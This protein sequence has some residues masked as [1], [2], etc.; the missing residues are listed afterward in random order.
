M[1]STSHHK[2]LCFKCEKNGILSCHGCK[3]DFC[4]IHVD[5]H[6][7]ELNEQMEEIILKRD[8]LHQ[9]IIEQTIKPSSHP[10]IDRINQWEIQSIRKIHQTAD[11]TRENLLPLL[12]IHRNRVIERLSHLTEQL[13]ISRKENDYM[14][15]DFKQWMIKLKQLKK[16]LLA[17]GIIRFIDGEEK[18][19]LVSKIIIDDTSQEYF[20]NFS[21]DIIGLEN[22]TIIE[23]GSTNTMGIARGYGEYSSK[24]HRFHFQIIHQSS[25]GGC[26]F[27]IVSKSISNQ[28]IRHLRRM[29]RFV[30]PSHRN[31][32]GFVYFYRIHSNMKRKNIVELIINCDEQKVYLEDKQSRNQQEMIV[33][34]HQCPF[35]W[36][37]FI[38]LLHPADR[39]LLSIHS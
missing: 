28:L 36:Q 23:H 33:N 38:A 5:E 31:T 1:S 24:Q 9:I 25:N 17:N 29:N 19:T 8:R 39:V 7:K 11:E 27:G 12:H 6:R 32:D 14:E 20:H 18:T 13:N 10:L 35:P 22:G 26:Y 3:K 30:N 21:G 15:T 4:S 16:D 34:I 2:H 37:L